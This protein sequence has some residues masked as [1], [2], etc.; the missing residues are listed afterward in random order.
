MATERKV[1]IIGAGC[2]GLTA[3]LYTARNALEPLILEGASPGGQL[4]ITTEVEN[5]PGFVEGIMGPQLIQ[6]M[7]DQAER[8]GAEFIQKDADS[9]DLSERPFTIT[10]GGETYK[11]Q[12]LIVAT[13]ARPNLLGLEAE[14]RLMGHGVSVCA[15]CDGPFFRDKYL[16]VIGGGDSAMEEAIFLTRFAGRVTIVHRRDELRAS[17]IMQERAMN[18]PKID[19]LWSHVLVD[20][21][22]DRETAV[23]GAKVKDVK[24]GEVKEVECGGV[25][26][27]LGHTPNTE[28]VMGQLELDAKGYLV[29]NGRSALT[30]VEGVFA[31]G[32]VTD[33]RYRQAV[34][35]AGMGCMAALDA[36]RF[37]ESAE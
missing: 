29:A 1:V 26:L 6:T 3:A 10:A 30:S 31:A 4:M 25:F 34:T 36:Q 24:T 28:L 11:A 21:I 35:A 9:L 20:I 16:L 15:T 27:A 17:K 12:A 22:G 37:L 23:T 13:G 14:Q 7:R 19:F 5:Y 8:F 2:A 33:S 18:N 32:D